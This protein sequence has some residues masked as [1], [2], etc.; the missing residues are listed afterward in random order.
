[1]S[2][3]HT[4]RSGR[5]MNGRRG[6][7]GQG[8]PR[9]PSTNGRPPA[10]PPA[11]QHTTPT[12]LATLP[13]RTPP[14]PATTPAAQ[15]EGSGAAPGRDGS[16]GRPDT[17]PWGSRDAG[18]VRSGAERGQPP[19]FAVMAAPAPAQP[20]RP[21]GPA[22][23]DEWRRN[24][25]PPVRP[26]LPRPGDAPGSGEPPRVQRHE[27]P[28]EDLRHAHNGAST[29]SQAPVHAAEVSPTGVP[30]GPP[31]RR[32]RAEPREHGPLRPEARGE[33]GTLI[34]AL[35]SVFEQDRATA[36]QSN[37]ARCGICYLHFRQDEL[38]YREAEGFY[39]CDGCVQ[40]LGTQQIIMVRRQQR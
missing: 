20:L 11:P 18:H 13:G 1:M 15:A 27:R 29:A 33:V 31:P 5:R 21:P 38:V 19:A 35:H 39:V 6:R 28:R 16:R 37:S 22:H 32:E 14:P 30:E 26:S 34:D 23:A 12:N 9:G 3:A 8:G 4:N 17:A 10:S 2:N 25:P 24:A 7:N 40:A 36:S